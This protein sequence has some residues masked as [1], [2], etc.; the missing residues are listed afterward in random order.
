MNITK[1]LS[2]YKLFPA[3]AAISLIAMGVVLGCAGDGGKPATSARS[4]KS[5][6]E[7]WG[8]NCGRCHTTR[9]PTLYSDAQWALIMQHMRTMANIPGEDARKIEAFLKASN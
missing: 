2:P 3:L 8:E 4:D 1:I 6:S 9:S 7:L 5:G